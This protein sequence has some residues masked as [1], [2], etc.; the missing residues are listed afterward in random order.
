MDEGI[1]PKHPKTSKIKSKSLR[2][3]WINDEIDKN[4]A[5]RGLKRKKSEIPQITV[6]W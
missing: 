4:A 1:K 3:R 6:G 2:S 5:I